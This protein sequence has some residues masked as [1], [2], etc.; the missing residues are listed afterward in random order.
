[1]IVIFKV[2]R[3]SDMVLAIIGFSGL[4][5][6]V[7]TLASILSAT[8]Y[9]ISI[10]FSCTTWMAD[11][12][13]RS[14]LSRNVEASELG[15][16]FTLLTI[17]D[18]VVPPIASSISSNTFRVSIDMSL[19]SLNYILA[20]IVCVISLVIILIIIKLNKK[21]SIQLSNN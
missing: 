18:G 15:K 11:V 5:L 16:I 20:A 2:F 17:V 10:A 13:L 19:P 6:R 4:L 3:V 8:G 12:G 7:V 14:H 21:N 9:Y 1:M